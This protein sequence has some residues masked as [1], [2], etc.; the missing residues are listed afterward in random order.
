LLILFSIQ[1]GNKVLYCCFAIYLLQHTV[2][3]GA[4][5]RNIVGGERITDSVTFLRRAL[6][7]A[8]FVVESPVPIEVI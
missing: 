8:I 4:L 3:D 2:N 6:E 7:M 1:F 5:C